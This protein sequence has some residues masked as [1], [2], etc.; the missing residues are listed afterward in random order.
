[1]RL[2]QRQDWPLQAMGFDEWDELAGLALDVDEASP[3]RSVIKRTLPG[4]VI[5][6]CEGRQIRLDRSSR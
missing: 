6:T 2:W 4:G 5:V 3:P 1:M